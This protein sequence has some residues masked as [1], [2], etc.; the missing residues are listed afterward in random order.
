MEV[1]QNTSSHISELKQ[2][3][4]TAAEDVRSLKDD[5]VEYL[6]DHTNKKITTPIRDVV[7]RIENLGSLALKKLSDKLDNIPTASVSEKI[8]V[9]SAELDTLNGILPDPNLQGNI[10]NAKAALSVVQNNYQNE[11]K[12]IYLDFQKSLESF[13][14]SHRKELA[15][16]EE[17][18]KNL[19]NE[20]SIGDLKKVLHSLDEHKINCEPEIKAERDKCQN[21][22]ITIQKTYNDQLDNELSNIKERLQKINTVEN[23]IYFES[24]SQTGKK[25]L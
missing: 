11:I 4:S 20:D 9:I 6:R 16:L 5:F 22:L 24:E 25:E 3:L 1:S 12:S 17:S 23:D 13:Q 18:Y 21:L 10:Q 8:D 14:E 7:V 19:F 2:S 15:T